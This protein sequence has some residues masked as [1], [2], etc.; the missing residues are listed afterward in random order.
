MIPRPRFRRRQRRITEENIVLELDG[1]EIPLRVRRHPRARRLTLRIDRTGRGVVITIPSGTDLSEGLEFAHR[2]SGWL[3]DRLEKSAPPILVDDGTTVPFL[4]SPHRIRH[5]PGRRGVVTR[6][7][8]EIHVSGRPEHLKRRLFDWLKQEAR[9][10]LGD[11]SREKAAIIGKTVG[12]VSVRDTRS[13]WG[14]CSAAGNLSFC[15]RLILA[16]EFVLDYVAAH[17]VAHLAE[18]NHGPRFWKLVGDLTADAD[19]ARAWL[20]VHGEDLHR[21]M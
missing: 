3:L 15:W 9:R 7:N 6:R 16:P 5:A 8:G 19:R 13:R 4:D 20:R 2:Q 18:K 11:A 14:S 17:E 1:R 12:R 21:Y 10:K